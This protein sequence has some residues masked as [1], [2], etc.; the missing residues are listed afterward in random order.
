MDEKQKGLVSELE[1]F[2]TGCSWVPL[3]PA[4]P[5]PTKPQPIC[6]EWQDNQAFHTN[7]LESEKLLQVNQIGQAEIGPKR[8]SEKFLQENP[9]ACWDSA[10]ALNIH[11]SFNTRETNIA[12]KSQVNGDDLCRYNFP[13]NDDEMWNS[14]SFRELLALA[15]AASGNASAQTAFNATSSSFAPNFYPN[16]DSRQCT[17]TTENSSLVN[18]DAS[19]GINF[20]DECNSIQQNIPNYGSCIRSRLF[21]DLNFP[22]RTAD[23]T[24]S[25]MVSSQFAPITPEK[26]TKTDERRGLA[27]PN[28]NTDE[29]LGKKDVQQKEIAIKR[30]GLGG[31]LQMKEH[32]Q[33]VVDH[34]CETMSTQLEENHKP[35]KGGTEDIDLSKTPQQKPRR[36]KHRPKVIKGQSQMT[37]KPSVGRPSDPQEPTK[38]KRKYVRRRGLNNN[39]TATP[40]NREINESNT[41]TNAPSSTEAMTS[42]RKYVRR[43]GVD[44]PAATTPDQETCETDPQ[45]VQ[46]TK[47]TCR[48]SLKFDVEGQGSD[49]SSLHHHPSPNFDMESQAQNFNAKDQSGSTIQCIQGREASG[50]K[51]ELNIVYDLTCSTKQAMEG[52]LSK[53]EGHSSCPSPHSKTDTLHDKSTLTDQ[54]VCTRGKCQIIF[55]DFTHDEEGNNV[56]LIMNS[57]AQSIQKSPSNSDSSS[58][59]CLMQERQERGIKRQHMGTT[60]EAEFCR[61]NSTGT[62]HNSLQAYGAIF[63]QYTD[64]NYCN[65]GMHFP[66]IYSTKRIEKGHNSVISSMHST[67]ITSENCVTAA[68]DGTQ[69]EQKKLKILAAM[70]PTERLEKKRSKEPAPVWNL[71]PTVE[72]RGKLPASADSGATTSKTAQGFEILQP[73]HKKRSK[74]PTQDPKGPTA[75]TRKT[76]MTKKRPKKSLLVNSAVQNIRSDHQFVARSMGPPLAIT[77]IC[78]SP[79]DAII[80]QFNQLDLNAKSSQKHNAFIACHMNYQE[81]H[82]IV[83][84]QRNGALIPFDSSFDQVK[85]SRPRPKVDLDDETSRVWKLLLENINSEGIDGTD[86]EKEKWWEEERRVFHGRADSFIARMHLVQGDR[87]FSPWKGSVLD[88]VIGVFLTQNVSDHLSSSAF[89]SLAARFAFESE[90]SQGQSC[91]ENVKI[92]VKEPEGHGLDTDD[93]FGWNEGLNKPTCSEDSKMI[94]ESDYNDLREANSVKSPGDSFIGTI[95]K[96]N[97][98]RQ[99]S[100][101]SKNCPDTSRESAV[102]KSIGFIGD[103]K[104][105]DDT[106]S[107]QNSVTYSQNSADSVIAQTAERTESCSPRTLE[108]ESCTAYRKLSQMSQSKINVRNQGNRNKLCEDGQLE[109]ESMASDSQNQNENQS[110]ITCGEPA[111][112]LAPSSGAQ[113]AERFDV[114]QKNGKSSNDTIGKE[115]CDTELSGLSAESA[116]QATI[117][118]FLA[119]SREIPKFGSEKV[120]SSNKH[121]IDVYKKITE[122]PTGKLESQ[123]HCQENNYKMQEVSNIPVFPQKLTD[124]TGSSNIDNLRIPEHKEIGSNL[125]DPGKTARQ[126]KANGG[127]IRKEKQK[128]VNWDCLRKQA[129]EGGRRR[130]RTANTK[131]SVDWEAVRCADVSEIAET[132]KE[133]GMNNVLAERIQEFLNRLIRDHG[134]IDLEW[135]RDVPPDKAKEYL[136]SVRGLGLKSVECVRLLTLHHLAF[137]VDTNVG[138]IAVRLGWVP[139]QPLPES[140]QLHLLELYPILESIQ[141]YLWPRLCKLDQRTLYELHYQMITFGKVFCTKSKPNCN[142]CPLRGECRHFASAFASAR[143]ALPGTEDKSIVSATENNAAYQNPVKIIDPLQLRLPQAYQLEAHTEASNSEPII[144]APATPEPI[145]EVPATP[146]TDQTQVPECDIEDNN[147]EDPDDIPTIRLNMEQ[148][149]HNLQSFFIQ[150]GMELQEGEGDMSKALVALTPEAASIPMPKLKNVNRLRTEHQV[151]ELPDSHPLLHRMDKRE[152]DD[153]SSYLLAIWTPGET[154]D[155]IRPPER[156]I[157]QE[158]GNLCTNETCFSCNSIREGN[159]QTVR[160]TLLIPCRTAMRGSFPL[161]GTYFQVNEVFAD[162]ESSL[163]PINVPRDWLWNLPRRTVYFGTSIPTIFKGLSTE[164]IQCCFWRGFVCVRGFDWKTRAPRPLIARLHFPASKDYVETASAGMASEHDSSQCKRK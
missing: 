145:I 6:T 144:E 54:K 73:P 137:P 10:N 114:L 25:E 88:S 146:E 129:Q 159:S 5:G 35:D 116:T 4:K 76:M 141:K 103:E 90:S 106:L 130:E 89:M 38:V 147:L 91:Q 163:N 104:D 84:Y 24:F 53:P 148:F 67:V 20:P 101:V 109:P 2:Q 93:T 149:A 120:H 126:P 124:I 41:N 85:K 27:M 52:Y 21:F 43:K 87:R 158:S 13:V 111:L 100:A 46:Y 12:E 8:A 19:L 99:L 60:F 77:W 117:Q 15:D 47:N 105:L 162:H 143:L 98:S 57:D 70:G 68:A 18:L 56:Q 127:R 80:E 62:L 58:T 139:L 113:V 61:S 82:A 133:R 86:E 140:L 66:A 34:V 107:S 95:P 23:A 33:L 26:T 75:D 136:L 164:D 65:P 37:P 51:T 79:V 40:L 64:N 123:F 78:K 150:K 151:Y 7:G 49:E 1:D 138:R 131:D 17:I 161:N 135:L 45:T 115:L 55:S 11:G 32:S 92:T 112:H 125:K 122:N 132:I 83:P 3:T 42:K 154:A 50:K 128:P 160:G 118:K 155:S 48:R 121:P 39:T 110:D 108:A 28:L 30:I 96:D 142:A 102:N 157:S 152:P 119:I 36:K 134:S 81:Q 156:C 9:A 94:P 59:A 63:S 14:V 22:S 69:N 97:L 16:I 31:F 71:A 44:K 153:P 29:M 74:G 72:I